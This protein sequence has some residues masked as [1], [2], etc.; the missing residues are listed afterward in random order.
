M[1]KEQLQVTTMIRPGPGFLPPAPTI[2]IGRGR[3]LN[4]PKKDNNNNNGQMATVGKLPSLPTPTPFSGIGRGRGRR[5]EIDLDSS[6]FT[7]AS[8]SKI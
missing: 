7:D 5:P 2:G 4:G 1:K 3:P 8:V 6:R